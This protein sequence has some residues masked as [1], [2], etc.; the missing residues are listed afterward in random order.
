MDV[1]AAPEVVDF[2]SFSAYNCISFHKLGFD[3]LLITFIAFAAR[4]L[5]YLG[6]MSLDKAASIPPPTA[7]SSVLSLFSWVKL[8]LISYLHFKHTCL[9]YLYTCCS[10]F[11][12]NC[13]LGLFGSLLCLLTYFWLFAY[14]IWLWAHLRELNGI[15]FYFT[16]QTHISNLWIC[17]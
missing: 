17:F 8:Y 3:S 7:S 2:R 16:F 6:G 4:F 9:N 13:L 12:C 11:C 10:W 14:S 1:V 5:H 15:S